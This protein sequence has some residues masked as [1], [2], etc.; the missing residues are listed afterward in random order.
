[1]HRPVEMAVESRP[2]P[3]YHPNG[4]YLVQSEHT[5]IIFLPA[6]LAPGDSEKN[7]KEVSGL[8]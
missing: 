6:Y 8:F 7:D 1:M 5:A 2:S 4:R 3:A